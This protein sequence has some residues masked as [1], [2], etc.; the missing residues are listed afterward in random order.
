MLSRVVWRLC[1]D[2]DNFL[3]FGC[4]EFRQKKRNNKKLKKCQIQ[5][6]LGSKKMLK[7]KKTLKKGGKIEKSLG[8]EKL[9]DDLR[10][11]SKGVMNDLDII[12]SSDDSD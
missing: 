2:F 3:W 6:F 9:E 12:C 11:T 1:W 8:L 4:F 7:K 5:N 10:K